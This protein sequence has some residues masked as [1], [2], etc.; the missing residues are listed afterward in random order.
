MSK[1][2]KLLIEHSNQCKE[3]MA[4]LGPCT[5][6]ARLM[7]NLKVMVLVYNDYFTLNVNHEE[8]LIFFH[9]IVYVLYSKK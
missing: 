7:Q 3:C 8:K 6:Y 1:G 9:R 4:L 2:I 5:G